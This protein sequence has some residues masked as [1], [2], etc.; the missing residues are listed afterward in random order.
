MDIGPDT[1]LY[2]YIVFS[3]LACLNT[4]SMRTLVNDSEPPHFLCTGFQLRY[5]SA[6]SGTDNAISEATQTE[7][8]RKLLN[9]FTYWK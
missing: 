1:L 6:I 4:V 8:L 5:A 7:D 3:L 2:T 9:P